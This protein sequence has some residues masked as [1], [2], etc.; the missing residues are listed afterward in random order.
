MNISAPE[1]SY[2]AGR[3]DWM[4]SA[5]CWWLT[6]DEFHP[7]GLGGQVKAAKTACSHC[8]VRAECLTYAMETETGYREGVYGGTSPRER[9]ALARDGWRRGDPVP[10]IRLGRAS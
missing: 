9:A 4:D 2:R 8:T 6:A 5:L 7:I 3:D 10:A 1:T